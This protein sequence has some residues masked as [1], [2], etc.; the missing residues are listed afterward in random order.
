MEKKNVGNGRDLY[1]SFIDLEKAYKIDR[2]AVLQVHGVRRKLGCVK[3]CK[4][5]MRK[6]KI[7][8]SWIEKKEKKYKSDK[9]V[10]PGT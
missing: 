7:V 2:K 5:S 1:E 10:R 4:V 6:V 9:L 3:L 8:C